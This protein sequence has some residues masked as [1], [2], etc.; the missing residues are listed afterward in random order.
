MITKIAHI[1][2][3]A[4]L[5]GAGTLIVDPGSIPP[6][7]GEEPIGGRPPIP[8]PLPGGARLESDLVI[9]LAEVRVEKG[10]QARIYFEVTALGANLISRRPIS[11]LIRSGTQTIEGTFT[12]QA[13]GNARV[14]TD[15]SLG[16]R[17]CPRPTDR[18]FGSRDMQ[19]V[20]NPD[21]AYPE[22]NFQNN[23]AGYD[24]RCG[25]TTPDR[26]EGVWISREG[27][28]WVFL[29]VK[30]TRNPAIGPRPSN[31]LRISFSAGLQLGDDRRRIS[32]T[33]GRPGIGILPGRARMVH[34]LCQYEGARA[35]ENFRTERVTVSWELANF[36]DGAWRWHTESVTVPYAKGW[37]WTPPDRPELPPLPNLVGGFPPSWHYTG[38]P[39]TLNRFAAIR[40]PFTVTN[41]GTR[42][43]GQTSARVTAYYDNLRRVAETRYVP[44]GT[45]A[46]G[47][48]QTLTV[49]LPPH[50]NGQCVTVA[51][52]QVDA[53]MQELESDE[54]VI[55]S[56]A[57]DPLSLTLYFHFP[58]R[59]NRGGVC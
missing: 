16:G 52:L 37:S 33:N 24:F 4:F 9:S 46:S 53:D 59:P 28:S 50:K 40:V 30:Y 44:V 22:S 14:L 36:E 35:A 51:V 57:Q 39:G 45:L 13:D 43:A 23:E 25:I 12:Q 48:V 34:F 11:Y 26:L 7:A 58:T 3:L 41:M 18:P 27:P 31:I 19:I 56:P 54:A 8:V 1:V 29:V 42:G 17:L 5:V 6:L 38:A 32:C 10:D 20:I 2:V 55:G 49:D 21:R 15:Q 47:Q